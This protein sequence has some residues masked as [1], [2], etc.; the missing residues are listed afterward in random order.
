MYNK[1][2][3]LAGLEKVKKDLVSNAYRVCLV[4]ST[5]HMKHRGSEVQRGNDEKP[6]VYSICS[7]G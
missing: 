2:Y 3:S 4:A 6:F 5:V 1:Q 7:I